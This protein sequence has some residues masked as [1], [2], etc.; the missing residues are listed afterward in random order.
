MSMS[1]YAVF[2]RGVNVGGRTIKMAELKDALSSLPLEDV[3]TLLASGN[4]V[5]RTRLS[6][7]ALAEA[8]EA[9]L[10]ESFGYDARVVVLSP[11]RLETL[12]AACPFP[13]DD[14]VQH[15][16]ITLFAEA[17]AA[18]ELHRD[19]SEAGA[20]VVQLGPEALAWTVSKGDTLENPMSKLSQRASRQNATV[21]TRNLRTLLKV[22]AAAA[23]LD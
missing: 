20:E 2:L 5:C 21:T 11:K 13:P 18:S 15:A 12:I 1:S 14:P 10:E 8:V 16:Y 22:A 19:A 4:F 17:K 9:R 6:A 3:K 23:A 7:K